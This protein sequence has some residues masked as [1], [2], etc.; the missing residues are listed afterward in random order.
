MN[1][2]TVARTLLGCLVC[3]YSLATAQVPSGYVQFDA[4]RKEVVVFVHGVTGDARETWTSSRTR[5]YWPELIRTDERFSRANV[6]VFSY[7]SPKLSNAQDVEELA[8]KLGDSLTDVLRV[9][10]KLYFLTHSMGGLIV[11]EMLVLKAVPSAKVPLIY[12]FGTPSAGADLSGIAAAITRNPQ[13]ENLRPFARDSDV[14]R[15]ARSWL[16]TSQDPRRQYP[17][18]IWS[19]CAYELQGLVAGKLIVPMLS[20]SHLCSTSPRAAL[21]D[22]S[23]MVKPEDR[24]AEPYEYFASAYEFARSPIATLLASSSAITMHDRASPGFDPNALK[25]KFATIGGSTFQ[26]ECGESRTGTLPVALDVS[27]GEHVV[28]AATA[29]QDVRGMRSSFFE[30]IVDTSGALAVK[31]SVSGLTGGHTGR[32]PTSGTASVGIQYVVEERR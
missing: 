11:R 12:F 27:S 16:A 4:A 26:V 13:F 17:Q 18:R 21:A 6:W 23:T 3:I 20:A 32:C 8:L 22:H 25:L 28:A 15:F 1:P 7:R 24:T 30:P 5:S 10:D 2:R 9:H 19:Y 29:Y 31:Y 14:A